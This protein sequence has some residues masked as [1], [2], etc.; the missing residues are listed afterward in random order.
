MVGRTRLIRKTGSPL[1]GGW[2]RRKKPLW[3]WVL[4]GV[5]A[6]AVAGAALWY[7]VLR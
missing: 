6:L 4:G 2:T 1:I 7:F 5:V 3:P